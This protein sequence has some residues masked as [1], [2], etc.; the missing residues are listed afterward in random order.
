MCVKRL[1]CPFREQFKTDSE[2]GDQQ[3]S[4]TICFCFL[5]QNRWI[6][7]K[8]ISNTSSQSEKWQP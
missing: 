4:I 2:H 5:L 1:N 6:N 7:N 3:R 8:S